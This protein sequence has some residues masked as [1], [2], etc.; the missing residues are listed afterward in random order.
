MTRALSV[1]RKW[2]SLKGEIHFTDD[3]GQP[4]YQ[5]TGEFPDLVPT[6][7]LTR[8][9]EVAARVRRKPWAW[10]PTWDVEG[11]LGGFRIQRR[12]LSWTRQYCAVGGVLDGALITGS[13]SDLRFEVR[14]GTQMLAR[15][16]G[17]PLSLRDRHHVEV[18]GEHEL[19]VVIA[20]L[21]ILLDQSHGTAAAAS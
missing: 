3:G 6:W 12:A 5:A 21:V 20:M 4:A 19:F 9:D 10:S 13:F 15:A 2:L 8:G 17:E 16:N 7:T 1:A 11:E 18:L 14:H